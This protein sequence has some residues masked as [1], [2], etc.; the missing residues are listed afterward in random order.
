MSVLNKM[1]FEWVTGGG[2]PICEFRY[3]CILFSS[4]GESVP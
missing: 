2:V 1:V 3:P 4:N